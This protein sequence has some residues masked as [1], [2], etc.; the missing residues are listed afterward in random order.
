MHNTWYAALERSPWAV[1]ALVAE[2]GM[3]RRAEVKFVM[4]EDDATALVR[5]LAPD[6]ALLPA[7]SALIATYR[8]LYFDTAELDLFHAHRRGR[9]VRQKV[10]IRHYPD[11]ELSFLEVKTRTTEDQTVKAR[12]ERLY[13]DSVLHPDDREFVR[14]A[15]PV[16]GHLEPQ[17]WV[18]YRRITLLGI[19]AEERVTVDFDVQVL[20]TAGGGRLKDVAVIEVKQARSNRASAAM[21]ALRRGGWHPRWVSKYCAAIALV[22]SD[23]R[24]NR[25]LPG[26]RAIEAVGTWAN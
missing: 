10:R 6:Y 15:C 25:L 22:R 11:R 5:V 19:Q 16:A 23:V 3:Q 2:R 18:T 17:V 12:R 20:G 7:G 9:R 26:M 14:A 21:M 1:P 4:P 8:S 13:G 24:A